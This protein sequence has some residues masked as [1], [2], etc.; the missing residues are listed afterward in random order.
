MSKDVEFTEYVGAR[1]ARLVRSVVLLGCSPEEAQDVVQTAMMRC[2]VNWRRVQRADDPNAYVYRVVM[3]SFA[4]AR[5]RRWGG[6]RPVAVIPDAPGGDETSRVDDRDAVVRSLARLSHD[7]RAV[8]VLRFYGHLGEGQMAS[9]LGIAPG[10]VKSRL[11]RALKLLAEDP[12]LA[13]LRG[14]S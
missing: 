3:N 7:Q 14:A 6:E 5:R 4:S 11:S 2:L 9:V 8:V 1:W 12:D 10:T 13:E